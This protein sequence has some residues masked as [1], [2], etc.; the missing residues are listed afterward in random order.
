MDVPGVWVSPSFGAVSREAAGGE[1]AEWIPIAPGSRKHLAPAQPPPPVIVADRGVLHPPYPVL[2]GRHRQSLPRISGHLR[3]ALLSPSIPENSRDERLDAWL[4]PWRAGADRSLVVTLEPGT[5]LVVDVSRWPEPNDIRV[6]D[7]VQRSRDRILRRAARVL[8]LAP[9]AFATQASLGAA[10]RR[11]EEIWNDR[12]LE[13]ADPLGELLVR[14]ARKLRGVLEDLGAHPRA[15]LRTEH[16]MLKLQEARRVDAKTIRWLS[17][18]PGRNTAE[19]AGGRQRVKA[20]KRYETIAT[21][22]NRVLRAFAALTVRETKRW[23]TAGKQPKAETDL[24]KAHQLRARRIE[25]LLRER[26][27]LE[28][29][30]PVKPNFPLRFDQRYREIWRAWQ[31]LLDRNSQTELEWMWQDRTFMELLSLRAAMKLQT[32]TARAGGGTLAHAPVLRGRAAPSQGVYLESAGIRSTFG[33]ER[34]EAIRTV[35]YLSGGHDGPLCAVASAG[36]GKEVWWNAIHAAA[37]TAVVGELPWT[38]GHA[39]DA[40]LDRWADRVVS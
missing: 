20:P 14:H 25:A 28:A 26:G 40:R 37:E 11:L 31:E 9:G 10:Y 22:E 2:E 6:D 32:A 18:Q 24:V 35:E 8:D 34:G 4:L 38:P 29:T 12:R 7:S 5:V 3:G 39:W 17:A 15:V 21:L 36:A 30:P 19:R 27:V 23:L 33:F 1:R 16:R 13:E